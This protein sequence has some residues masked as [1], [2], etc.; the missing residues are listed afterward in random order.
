MSETEETRY[1]YRQVLSPQITMTG[2]FE[3]HDMVTL[4][5]SNNIKVSFGDLIVNC[6]IYAG[7]RLDESV[8]QIEKGLRE[9]L[10]DDVSEGHIGGTRHVITSIFGRGVWGE[11]F[12]ENNSEAINPSPEPSPQ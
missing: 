10:E 8:W 4:S 12:G 1:R 3:A 7:K 11:E 6:Y 9:L 2:H 5:F